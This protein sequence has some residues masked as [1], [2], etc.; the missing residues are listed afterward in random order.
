MQR[1]DKFY[2]EEGKII[3]NGESSV[4]KYQINKH[5]FFYEAKGLHQMTPLFQ[6][7]FS[8]VPTLAQI[9]ARCLP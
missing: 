2:H 6:F 1:Y 5:L 3:L 8:A 9:N 4:E 7:G